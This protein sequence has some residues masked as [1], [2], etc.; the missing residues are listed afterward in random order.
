MKRLLSEFENILWTLIDRE[1]CPKCGNEIE[2]DMVE[3]RT[4]E[5]KGGIWVICPHCQAKL[6]IR[7]SFQK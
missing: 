4:S 3:L 1:K 7:F 5:K 6:R 2:H